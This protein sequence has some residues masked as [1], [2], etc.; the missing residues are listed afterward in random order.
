ML[1]KLGSKDINVPF[2]GD[3][4]ALTSLRFFA[5]FYVCIF[6][7]RVFTSLDMW[8]FDSFFLSGYLGVDFF[9]ILSGFI[10]TYTYYPKTEKEG[11]NARIFFL[12]RVARIYPVHLLTLFFAL[13][14]LFTSSKESQLANSDIFSLSYFIQNIFLVHA[15]GGSEKLSFNQPSWSI[16]S[17]AFAYLCFPAMIYLTRVMNP[18]QVFFRALFLFFVLYGYLLVFEG[19]VLTQSTISYSLLRVIPDFLMGVGGYFLYRKYTFNGDLLKQYILSM[20]TLLFCFFCSGLDIIVVPVFAWIIFLVAVQAR[21]YRKSWLNHPLWVYLGKASYSLYM[22]HFC[23]WSG[24]MIFTSYIGV[25][26]FT[27]GYVS[28]Y[29]AAFTLLGLFFPVAI[30]VYHFVEKPM[31]S[32]IVRKFC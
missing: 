24:V 10:L 31:H 30:A 11:F 15:W 8:Y 27:H 2:S 25:P 16:S 9:F 14:L 13:A 23:V 21:D 19:V 28:D 4:S 22:V 18:A 29:L 20:A 6:H 17:E 3:I 26:L 5:A 7:I 12:R 1:K 32:L